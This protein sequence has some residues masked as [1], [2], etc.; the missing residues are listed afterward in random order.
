M[1]LCPQCESDT[2]TLNEG[3]CENCREEN[4][5]RLDQHNFEFDAWEKLS[6]NEIDSRIKSAMYN[7]ELTSPPDTE[8]KRSEEL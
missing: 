5:S 2:E 1:F 4:Q 6:G 8:P 7:A 3:Y